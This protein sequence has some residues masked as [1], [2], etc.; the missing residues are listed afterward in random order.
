MSNS[1]KKKYRNFLY[2]CLVIS[3]SVLFAVLYFFAYRKIPSHLMVRAGTEQ[4]LDFGLPLTGEVCQP[5]Y[6]E[7]LA[8]SE[9][10]ISNI[11][12]DAIFME[13]TNSIT[14]N[15]SQTEPYQVQ[16]KLFGVIPF[17]QI[18]VEVMKD[19]EL[20]PGGIPIGI[21]VKTQGVLVIGTGEFNNPE[22]TIC[23]PAKYVLKTG[24]YILKVNNAPVESKAAFMEAVSQSEGAELVLTVKREESTF[25]VKVYPLQNETGE[26][27][28]GIW[29]RDNAQGVGTLTYIDTEGKFGALGHGINDVDTSELLSVD[30][31]SLYHTDIIAIRKGSN[32]TPGEMTGLIEYKEDKILGQISQNTNE[33]IFGNGNEELVHEIEGDPIPIALKQEI[34][35]GPAEIM[36]TIDGVTKSYAVEITAL[37]L[38]NDNINRGIVLEI[39]DP[40]LLEKTG[41]IIQG[42]SGAP[43][44]KN[45]KI[46]GAVTHVLVQDVTRGY[47]IFIENMM[48]HN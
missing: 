23:S 1:A 41:G 32:G 33:G 15:A 29:I 4:N 14:L 42:M 17:K 10:G 36:C 7:A 21:Y 27:K 31:G 22:G 30:S 2:V 20:I 34:E 26:Y 18:T 12:R 25:D 28:L 43:I 45:G 47:G 13:E 40:E 5:D 16:L 6:E 48:E 9:Q 24:D 44:I 39:T 46:I 35:V 3:L 8:V 37:H 38:D 19:L 11:P